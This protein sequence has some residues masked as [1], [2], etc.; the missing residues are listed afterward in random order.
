MNDAAA[1]LVDE[2]QTGAK[3]VEVIGKGCRFGDIHRHGLL[4]LR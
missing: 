4:L 2:K 1:C 3:A